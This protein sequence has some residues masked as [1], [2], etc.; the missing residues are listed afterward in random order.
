MYCLGKDG[1]IHDTNFDPKLHWE[2]FSS[3]ERAF[4][5]EQA[6][7]GERREMGV[8]YHCAYGIYEY[9]ISDNGDLKLNYFEGC[10]AKGIDNENYIIY[11]KNR[12]CLVYQSDDSELLRNLSTA[13]GNEIG[14]IEDA[15]EFSV[16]D[17]FDKEHAFKVTFNVTLDDECKRRTIKKIEEVG[18]MTNEQI[19]SELA[20]KKTIDVTGVS[21]NTLDAIM[22]L[23]QQDLMSPEEKEANRLQYES[24]VR[25][26]FYDGVEFGVYNKDAILDWR[27]K[28]ESK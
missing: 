17:R 28:H 15:A 2:R 27:K 16:T 18:V 8:V 26:A 19:V 20:T 12:K 14:I 11:T 1:T 23:I 5:L 9:A 21:K 22:N 7:M 4:D 24:D 3:F 6:M 13:I 10:R 25:A